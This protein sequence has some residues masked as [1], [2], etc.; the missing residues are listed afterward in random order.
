MGR[1]AAQK[2]NGDGE[3]RRYRI[4]A[5]DDR[6]REALGSELEYVDRASGFAVG[7]DEIFRFNFFLES[8]GSRYFGNTSGGLNRLLK[9]SLP[10]RRSN[11]SA[12]VEEGGDLFGSAVQ[13]AARIC[14]VGRAGGVLVSDEVK[15]ARSDTEYIL[16]RLVS[17]H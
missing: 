9:N 17:K 13:M 6:L 14:A 11:D 10:I 16:K 4:S 1:L 8:A 7:D 3:R 15:Y 12:V 2:P 5:S